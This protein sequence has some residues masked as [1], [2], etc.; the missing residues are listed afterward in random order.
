MRMAT[1]NDERPSKCSKASR[2]AQ[3]AREQAMTPE[4]RAMASERMKQMVSFMRELRTK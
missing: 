2:D 4:Q 1:P 3:I